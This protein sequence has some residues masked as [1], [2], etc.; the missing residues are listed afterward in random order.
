MD[1]RFL[2]FAFRD[3]S[4]EYTPAMDGRFLIFAFRDE[5]KSY[6][7]AGCALPVSGYETTADYGMGLVPIFCFWN[8]RVWMVAVTEDRRGTNAE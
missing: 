6:T 2:I 1:G 8:R 5:S 4:K 7:S 3:E